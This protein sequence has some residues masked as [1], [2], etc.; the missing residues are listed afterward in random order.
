MQTTTY[1]LKISF[2]RVLP[3]QSRLTPSPGTEGMKVGLKNY[4]VW[5]AR[6]KLVHFCC[7]ALSVWPCERSI[8]NRFYFFSV[9]L[10]SLPIIS[11]SLS[12]VQWQLWLS[13]LTQYQ[14]V[15]DRQ[16]ERQTCRRSSI[17]EKGDSART[18]ATNWHCSYTLAKCLSKTL[19]VPYPRGPCMANLCSNVRSMNNLSSASHDVLTQVAVLTYAIVKFEHISRCYK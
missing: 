17:A 19:H 9:F 1:W 13:V 5:A 6:W 4:S 14:R 2:F 3:T 7:P 16:T 15:T 8:A 10:L 11:A 18:L 12:N